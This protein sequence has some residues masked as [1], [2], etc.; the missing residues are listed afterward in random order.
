MKTKFNKDS[1]N[2][3]IAMLIGDG[4]ISKNNVYKIARS[5]K[6]RDYLEW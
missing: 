1:R 5:Y 4:T 2:L 3:L 6:Q